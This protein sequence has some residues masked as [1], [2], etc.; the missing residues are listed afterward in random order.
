MLQ[1]RSHEDGERNNEEVYPR[2][3]FTLLSEI[4]TL[5]SS[6]ISDEEE[7]NTRKR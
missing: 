3:Q 1:I 7:R 5:I 2:I 4:I 6:L